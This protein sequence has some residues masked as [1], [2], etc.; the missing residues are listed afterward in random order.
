M[1]SEEMKQFMLD[2]SELK[3]KYPMVAFDAWTPID[4]QYIIADINGEDEPTEINWSEDI[5]VHIADT[6]M[7]QY[8]AESGLNNDLVKDTIEDIIGSE[9]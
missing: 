8:D 4:F 5:H 3:A 6:L 1:H 7:L 2:Y 9:D